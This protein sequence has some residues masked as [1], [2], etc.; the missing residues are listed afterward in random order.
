M[1]CSNAVNRARRSR[2]ATSCTRCR[3]ID[4]LVRL[5]VRDAAAFGVFPSVGRLSSTPSAGGRVPPLFG[6]F[7]GTSRPS[8][9]PRTCMPDV[10]SLTFSGRRGGPSPPGVHGISRFPRVCVRPT[11][12]LAASLVWQVYSDSQMFFRARSWS[13]QSSG[14]DAFSRIG[15][16]ERG[17]LARP[18][19]S[20][21][22]IRNC[23]QSAKQRAKI[24]FRGRR[25]ATG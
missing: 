17:R 19:L 14:G 10:R 9:F 20:R 7:S 13:G 1:W 21:H 4:A 23:T 12:F 8:D 18:L 16:Q 6:S 24:I 5:C 15:R 25:K 2:R 3:A 11:P 22:P